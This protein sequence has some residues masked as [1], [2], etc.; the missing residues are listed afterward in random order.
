[1]PGADLRV[2]TLERLPWS[3]AAFDVVTGFNAF[4][5]APDI[6]AAFV[7]AARVTR[8]GGRIAA[9]NWGGVGPQDLVTVTHDLQALAPDAALV[10]RRPIGEPGVLEELLARGGPAA[11]G[12]RATSPCPTRRR[13]GTRSNA[14]CSRRATCA[15]SRSTWARNGRRRRA[16]RGR[17]PVPPSRRVLPVPQHLPMGRRRT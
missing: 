15:T 14:A 4:Q 12:R 8:P 10:P 11:V 9:C 1:M 3:D 13:T 2:G 5:F 6:V 17:R 7:E 16:G